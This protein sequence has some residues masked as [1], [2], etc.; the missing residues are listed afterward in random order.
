MTHICKEAQ[1]WLDRH[2]S[3][4]HS[5]ALRYFST[6]CTGRINKHDFDSTTD[7]ALLA[8]VKECS[9]CYA[10]IVAR[11]GPALLERQKRLTQYCCAILFGAVEEPEGDNLKISLTPNPQRDGGHNWRLSLVSDSGDTNSLI[12]NYCPFCGKL[13]KT[14]DYSAS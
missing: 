8:H 5:I 4:G 6:E 9:N 13:V 11:V 1:T 14:A 3:I 2:Y 10:W 7:M 12:I